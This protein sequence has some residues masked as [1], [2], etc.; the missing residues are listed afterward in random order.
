MIARETVY[1]KPPEIKT[2]VF[3]DEMMK[4]NLSVNRL[5]LTYRTYIELG[6]RKSLLTSK[7]YT[8]KYGLESHYLHIHLIFRL[9]S[10]YTQKNKL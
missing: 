1:H 4:L 10:A 3:P 9:T 8:M 5:L 7:I 6:C 2:S